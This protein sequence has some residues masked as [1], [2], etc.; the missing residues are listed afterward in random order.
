MSSNEK[1]G[2]VDASEVVAAPVRDVYDGVSW[3]KQPILRRLYF[4]MVFL[5]VG[6]S[7]L[8]Y[9]ASLLNGLQTMNSWQDC[10]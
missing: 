6:S 5:F 1:A 2:T 8:G 9:D 10:K 3:Y 7:T 4:L